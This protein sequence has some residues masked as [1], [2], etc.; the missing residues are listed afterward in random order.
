MTMVVHHNIS[1]YVILDNGILK[2]G[3]PANFNTPYSSGNH[4]TSC[5]YDENDAHHRHH[6]F[7]IPNK[8]H[9]AM[10]MPVTITK[11][12]PC[13]DGAVETIANLLTTIRVLTVV[14]IRVYQKLLLV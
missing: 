8:Y 2:Y 4:T 5:P 7:H 1:L 11:N 9:L 12:A 10:I 14:A 3:L 13:N 6:A